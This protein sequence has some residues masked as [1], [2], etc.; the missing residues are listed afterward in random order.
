MPLPRPLGQGAVSLRDSGPV[1]DFIHVDDVA[2]GLVR[3][4]LAGDESGFR[5]YNLSTGAGASLA[6]MA[7][8]VAGI[9]KSGRPEFEN[10]GPGGQETVRVL[11]NS[12]LEE[13]T[14]WRPEYG[15]HEGLERTYRELS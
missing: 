15:L 2:R 11:D 12:A 13:R 1:L 6:E 10:V 5:V 7:A 14:G 3:L 4:A 9:T 8:M